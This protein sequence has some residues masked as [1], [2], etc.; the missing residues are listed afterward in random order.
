MPRPYDLISIF[1][2]PY[3]LTR[4]LRVYPKYAYFS[5]KYRKVVSY[6]LLTN[7]KTNKGPVIRSFGYAHVSCKM[8]TG[9]DRIVTYTAKSLI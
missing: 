4:V 9:C 1:F 8:M 7:I 5:K 6:T 3:I 2:Y